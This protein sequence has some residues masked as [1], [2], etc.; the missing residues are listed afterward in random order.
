MRTLFLSII[1]SFSMVWMCMA[2]NDDHAYLKIELHQKTISYPPGTPFVAK[3]VQG[4]T[5]LSM[6]DLKQVNVY[7]ITK[8]IT[9]LV[10]VSWS[11]TPDKY[12]LNKGTLSFVNTNTSLKK[13]QISNKIPSKDHFKNVSK[14][15]SNNEQVHDNVYLIKKQYFSYDEETGYDV[16]LQ[17]SNGILF[18]YRNGKANAW[19]GGKSLPIKH[20]YI[21]QTDQGALK[22]SYN[23]QTQKIWWI[24]DKK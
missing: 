4:N 14:E 15:A 2:S 24:F 22:L 8:P 11:D 21:I 16:S 13:V 7:E 3:D 1:L 18:L 23:P 9:L 5:I 17:F 19:K 6:Y 20:K 10:Y 12:K